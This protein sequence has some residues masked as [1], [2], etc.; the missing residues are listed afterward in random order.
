M[1]L[2]VFIFAKVA[3]GLATMSNAEQPI[4]E[5][6]REAAEQVRQLA[7]IARLSDIRGDLEELAARFERLG[8]NADAAI[9]LG[10]PYPHGELLP[11]GCGPPRAGAGRE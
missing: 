11:I 4:P 6:Y 9:R 8:A 3:A 7:R 5:I 1:G 10:V 2:S